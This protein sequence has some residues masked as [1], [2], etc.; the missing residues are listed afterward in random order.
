MANEYLTSTELK[1]TLSLG[2]ETF[3]DEDINR[4]LT[5][6]SR[7]IDGACNRRFWKDADADQVRYYTPI[8]DQLVRIDDLVELDGVA[9]DRNRDGTYADAW[10]LDTDFTLEPAN[11]A[12]DGKP[13]ELITRRPN[14]RYS[15]PT[16]ASVYD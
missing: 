15:W 3:A 13:Y 12:A 4:A 1:K 8:S 10:T 11:A 5:A 7:G 2:G 6:A 14:G 16:G 9:T